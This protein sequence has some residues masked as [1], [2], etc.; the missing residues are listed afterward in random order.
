VTQQT[1]AELLADHVAGSPTAFA[2]LVRRHQDRLWAVALRTVGD[3]HTAADVV[4]DALLKAFRRAD[5]YRG[6]A[7]VG[8]WLHRVV[9]TTALDARRSASRAPVPA[10]DLGDLGHP[11]DFGDPGD[12]PVTRADVH[13]A[14]REL[15]DDQRAAVVLVDMVGLSVAEAAQ[16]LAVPQGTVK[17]RCFRARERLGVLLSVHHTGE[18]ATSPPTTPAAR[19]NPVPVRGVQE[20]R[21]AGRSS[22]ARE[23]Q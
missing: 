2:E 9:V 4:Q 23:D 13:A 7:A 20:R 8:T 6:E 17:S 1:D 10:S 11:G 3:P 5:T 21:A 14:L 19:G 18:V 15:S 22:S 12:T 16:T